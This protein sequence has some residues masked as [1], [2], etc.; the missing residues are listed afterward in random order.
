LCAFYE[1]AAKSVRAKHVPRIQVQTS[2]IAGVE[3][4]VGDNTNAEYLT[5]DA[6]CRL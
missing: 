6:T 4:V 3:P 5:L 2:A 1:I